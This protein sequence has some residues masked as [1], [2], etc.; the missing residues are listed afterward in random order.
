MTKTKLEALHEKTEEVC[1]AIGATTFEDAAT[2]YNVSRGTLN[3]FVD[4]HR[5]LYDAALAKYGK[6]TQRELKL[7]KPASTV[8]DSSPKGGS[9]PVKTNRKNRITVASA[10]PVK[11]KKPRGPAASTPK[12]L[13]S[14]DMKVRDS[15]AG[16]TPPPPDKLKKAK[17]AGAATE[18]NVELETEEIKALMAEV[19]SIEVRIKE[20]EQESV[21]RA[22]LF[23]FHLHVIRRRYAQHGMWE[24]LIKRY[25]RVKRSTAR[26]YMALAAKLFPDEMIKS[27]PGTDLPNFGVTP[28]IAEQVKE[29]ID[30]RPIS[31]MYD[32]YGIK[33]TTPKKVLTLGVCRRLF[34]RIEKHVTE[35]A[36]ELGEE[37][38]RAAKNATDKLNDCDAALSDLFD[39]VS[40]AKSVQSPALDSSKNPPSTES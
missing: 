2:K 24:R 36:E 23:G 14:L 38:K 32:D 17:S 6:S 25:C 11:A 39:L 12:A 28:E 34:A 35:V 40:K 16:M 33:T 29:K 27:V 37:G 9:F 18:S 7:T 5:V 22:V 19:T 8:K 31:K 15:L 10:P 3:T 21:Y 20:N 26:R 30:G 1:D 4:G 13:S